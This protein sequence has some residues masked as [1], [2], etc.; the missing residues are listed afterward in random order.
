MIALL[1]AQTLALVT[2]LK[3]IPGWDE[4]TERVRAAVRGG[5]DLVQVRAKTL[6]TQEQKELAS[7]LVSAVGAHARV[8][9]N[10]DP[11]VAK[12]SGADGV[13]LPES[14][15]GASIS[16]ARALLGPDA[17]IGKSVHSVRRRSQ[18]QARVP[19]TLSS[20]PFFPPVLM[21]VGRPAGP[22]ALPVLRTLYRS[23]LSASAG[24]RPRTAKV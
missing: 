24:S 8:V 3:L 7:L 1:H 18:L 12:T 22:R 14:G 15:A 2:D 20:A 19:P 16:R 10:G 5:V 21:R 13:H 11:E 6:S 9:V 17:L 4:L 23:R